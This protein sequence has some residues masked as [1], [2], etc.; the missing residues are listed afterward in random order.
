[1]IGK[2]LPRGLSSASASRARLRLPALLA[3][4]ALL[5]GCTGGVDSGATGAAEPKGGAPD[6]ATATLS[7]TAVSPTGT[8]GLSAVGDGFFAD[9]A[10][11]GTASA[12]RTTDLSSLPQ[13]LTVATATWQVSVQREPTSPAH[14]ALPLADGVVVGPDDVPLVVVD[15]SAGGSRELLPATVSADGRY[16]IAD[17][18]H[19]STFAGILLPPRFV[20]GLAEQ[21]LHTATASAV[22]EADQPRCTREDGAR[23]DGWAVASSG[24][25]AL[26]WCFGIPA[27]GS[28]RVLT[29]TNARRYPLSVAYPGATPVAG[30]RSVLDFARAANVGVKDRVL[31]LPR[32]EVS[33]SVKGPARLGTEFDR[34][35][36][37]FYAAQVGIETGFTALSRLGVKPKSAIRPALLNLYRGAR[38]GTALMQGLDAG[39]VI[40]ECFGDAKTLIK[41]YGAQGA[42]LVV[43]MTIAPVVEF[44][45][46]SF[47][48]AGDQLNGRDRYSISVT[49]TKPK[50]PLVTTLVGRWERHGGAL[51][52][53]ADGNGKTSFVVKCGPTQEQTCHDVEAFTYRRGADGTLTARV[54]SA[55]VL[56]SNG[57]NYSED[58]FTAYEVGDTFTLRPGAPNTLRVDGRVLWCNL[59]TAPRDAADCGA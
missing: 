40:V 41:A 22:E 11:T 29:V 12:R 33:F 26:K 31:L 51:N 19:F 43:A 5:A 56:G 24:P 1:M 44:F 35:A 36:Q 20:I 58:Y 2:S 39:K 53:R 13:E 57:I 49:Y 48:A 10:G 55:Q 25:D 3:A 7:P 17:T 28:G 42:I 30:Q 9:T 45:R 46:S 27:S 15:S 37:S 38:C 47:N 23:R 52:I 6:S 50:P 18:P 32:D 21:V 8:V 54:T 14:V 16:L 34:V 4:A 59:K